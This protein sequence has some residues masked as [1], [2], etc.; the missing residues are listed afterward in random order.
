[1]HPRQSESVPGGDQGD[2][3][4]FEVTDLRIAVHDERTAYEGTD[5]G[6]THG[7]KGRQLGPGWVE[8]VPGVSFAVRSGEVL[9]IV[10]ESGSGKTITVMGALGLLGKGAKSIDGSVKF[11]G[12]STDLWAE[13]A[14]PG[15][16]GQT[17]RRPE[18]MWDRR[19][20]KKRLEAFLGE[21]LDPVWR[22][23]MGS[24][25]GVMFQDP[26]AS[27]SPESVIG[28]QAGEV[29]HAHTEMDDLEIQER[30]L[31]ALGEVQLPGAGKFL[32]FRHE[33][34]RGE[35][36]RAMLAAALIKSPSLLIADEPLSGLDAPVAAA[37]LDLIRDMRRER[38]LAMILITHDLATVASIA[39]RVAVMYGGRIVEQASVVDVFHNPQHPYTEGLLGSIPSASLDRLRPIVGNP[40]RLVEIPAGRCSFAPRCPYVVDACRNDEPPL[41]KTPTG[42]AACLRAHELTLR[43]VGG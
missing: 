22:R 12:E 42:R 7:P 40:P 39:D 43:G 5:H 8:V 17:P 26:I 35:A 25:I 38:G 6:L 41:A 36:Q 37:I 21:S 19:R 20:R 4:L 30:V 23:L 31:E 27:W 9:A 16:R 1:M 34:S 2:A 33:L 28:E 15:G 24:E 3:P 13:R 14:R 18:S 10:G 11:M 32:S 29:L